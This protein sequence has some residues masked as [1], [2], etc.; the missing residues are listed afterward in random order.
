[1]LSLKH[2]FDDRKIFVI[3]TDIRDEDYDAGYINGFRKVPMCSSPYYIDTILSICISEHINVVIPT[4]TM[5][6]ESFDARR[7]E[8][9][10]HGISVACTSGFLSDVNSKD[11]LHNLMK[12]I[13]VNYLPSSVINSVEDAERFIRRQGPDKTFC[14]KQLHNCGAR[15][16]RIITTSPPS[17]PTD[18]GT[19][20]IPVSA[21]D[22]VLKAEG[23]MLMQEYLTGDEYSA[24]MF[25]DNGEILFFAL[26][27]NE[28]MVNGVAQKSVVVREIPEI[29]YMCE[30]VVYAAKLCGVVGFDIKCSSDGQPYIIDCNPRLTATVSVVA[31]A[32]LNLPYLAVKYALKEPLPRESVKLR[33]G[34]AC[35]RVMTD[36][37][38]NGG[39]VKW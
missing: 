1:M 12:K 23:S 16:F 3:G 10:Y 4:N 34:A 6:L 13:N 36:I 22:D 27:K 15:G 11:S 2:N 30:K 18:K 5:E 32:G 21:L 31:Y 39:S 24:D 17:C 38:Y 35:R 8:F 25:C 26:R 19:N 9:E 20:R 37:F 28:V 29:T 7:N 14:V 33:Y